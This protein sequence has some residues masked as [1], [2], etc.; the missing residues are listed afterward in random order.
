MHCNNAE[1]MEMVAAR[2]IFRVADKEKET[3]S[4]PVIME[5]GATETAADQVMETEPAEI[6]IVTET[7]FFI[8]IK[9]PG[10]KSYSIHN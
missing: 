8:K 5:T 4:L 7:K 10:F 1:T 3:A 2:E 9:F 6:K